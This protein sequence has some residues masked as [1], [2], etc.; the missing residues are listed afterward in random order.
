MRTAAVKMNCKFSI[1]L[2]S[3]LVHIV[4]QVVAVTYFPTG[5]QAFAA[6]RSGYWTTLGP[7]Y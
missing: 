1:Y 7:E 4:V 5:L 6:I 3:E 2:Y